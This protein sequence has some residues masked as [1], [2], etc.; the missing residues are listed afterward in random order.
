MRRK[1]LFFSQN[2][3]KGGAVRVF[4]DLVR[5]WPG[6]ED[7][8]TVGVN[9][10]N[11]C[12]QYYYEAVKSDRV[13]MWPIPVK[14][15]RDKYNLIMK[16]NLP[17][18]VRYGLIVVLII[19]MNPWWFVRDVLYFRR[20][21]KRQRF[22]VVISSNGGYPG[23]ELCLRVV[24]GAKLAGVRKIILIIHN[25]PIPR[26]TLGRWFWSIFDRT[27]SYCCSSI[28]SVCKDC[29]DTLN[30]KCSFTRDV[31]FIYNGLEIGKDTNGLKQKREALGINA[32]EKV[33]GAIGN[34]E[35]RK[36]FDYL[37]LAMAEVVRKF[38]ESRL[39]IIGGDTSDRKA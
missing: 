17:L 24:I 16:Y 2:H 7:D 15:K 29:A 23:G 1:I 11:E 19:A 33:I 18:H 21:L 35:R 37:I 34:L 20:Q 25:Y 9:E 26:N 10:A 28:I 32:D 6:E 22:D 31:G 27:V 4:A 3:V 13:K 8:I 14:S 12:F 36:G 5:N 39:I 30:E 38:P